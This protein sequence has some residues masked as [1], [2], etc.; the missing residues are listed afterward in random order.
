MSLWPSIV[1]V[2]PRCG[3]PPDD[4][5]EEPDEVLAP[6]P[7]VPTVA[8]LPRRILRLRQP[9]SRQR[10]PTTNVDP[11]CLLLL[12]LGAAHNMSHVTRRQRRGG[13]EAAD[14]RRAPKQSSI[15]TS[16]GAT[17][18][19]TQAL[20]RICSARPGQPGQPGRSAKEVTAAR[21]GPAAGTAAAAGRPARAAREGH[22]PDQEDHRE[23]Q[24]ERRVMPVVP[25][26]RRGR[27]HDEEQRDERHQD[28]G[29]R[30][31]SVSGVPL[32]GSSLRGRS[33]TSD[34]RARRTSW[35]RSSAPVAAGT[36]RDRAGHRHARSE[37]GRRSVHG[38]NRR[39]VDAS[40]DR[41]CDPGLDGALIVVSFA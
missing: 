35:P 34:A 17:S 18:R 31:A 27:H 8:V 40:R 41:R 32:S 4:D 37:A 30:P 22:P 21:L 3:V 9:R 26:R 5:P 11:T 10:Q 33:D 16:A 15:R 20:I 23:D 12:R 6:P 1:S 38:R 7:D 25:R 29:P 36:R 14:Q 28:A 13:T 19:T 39:R 24:E 2:P